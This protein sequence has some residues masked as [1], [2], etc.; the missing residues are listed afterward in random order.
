MSDSYSHWTDATNVNEPDNYP[1]DDRGSGDE[2][3]EPITDF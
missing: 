3:P 1:G 2:Q